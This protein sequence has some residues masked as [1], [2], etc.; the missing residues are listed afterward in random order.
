MREERLGGGVEPS[1]ARERNR[2]Q[3]SG[4]HWKE[5]AQKQ[6]T[7]I[8]SISEQCSNRVGVWLPAR[9]RA[10]EVRPRNLEPSAPPELSRHLRGEEWAS[11]AALQCRAQCRRE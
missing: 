4:K 9:R 5:K 3:P 11:G 6:E 2:L 10:G 8:G 1:G 7:R